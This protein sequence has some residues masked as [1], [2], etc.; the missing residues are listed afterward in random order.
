MITLMTIWR[1]ILRFKKMPQGLGT[2][3]RPNIIVTM[4]NRKRKSIS[5]NKISPLAAG[6]IDV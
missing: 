2:H 3:I 5:Q 1:P 4:H 6:P